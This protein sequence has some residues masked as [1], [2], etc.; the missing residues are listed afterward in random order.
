MTWNP[1][2][3]VELVFNDTGAPGSS[4]VPVAAMG[5]WRHSSGVILF[6]LFHRI[7]PL[8]RGN[9]SAWDN[10]SA[11]VATGGIDETATEF[12]AYLVPRSVRLTGS[13][14]SSAKRKDGIWCGC[15]DPG[16]YGLGV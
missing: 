10:W 8:G 5:R 1:S 3:A 13:P 7:L 14:A 2:T 16:Y 15:L 11:D 4:A 12:R 6:L 9:A